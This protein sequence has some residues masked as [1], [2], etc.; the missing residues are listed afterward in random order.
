[1]LSDYTFSLRSHIRARSP[2]Y[3]S[4]RPGPFE[5]IPARYDGDGDLARIPTMWYE[6]A[7]TAPAGESSNTTRPRL[8][9]RER[10]T[11][12]LGDAHGVVDGG[13]AP[14]SLGLD[15]A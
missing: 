1:M 15:N 3:H 6:T 2:D 14:F 10:A 12:R 8:S 13:V 7:G 5:A 11:G 9:M 4:Q